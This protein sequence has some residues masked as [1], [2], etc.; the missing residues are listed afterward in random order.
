MRTDSCRAEEGP[1]LDPACLADLRARP[2]APGS[3]RDT[4][5]E[6]QAFP[7]VKIVRDADALRRVGELRHRQYV[8]NQRKAYCSIAGHDDC[9]IEQADLRAVNIYAEDE[10]GITCAMR[11]DE[12]K[13]DGD[14]RIT[15]LRR[16]SDQQGIPHRLALTCSRLVRATHHSGRHAVQLIQF[17]RLQTVSLGWR[18]CIMQTSARL[19]P[20]FQK[21]E[22]NETGIWSDDPVAGWLQVLVL[23]TR[24]RPVQ[25]R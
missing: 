7:H 4:L 16:I 12:L 23:D 13:D 9:L 18:Y 6:S 17:V 15:L 2:P 8:Q 5:Q 1:P 25:Q 22:F 24:L 14:E 3:L 20:F 19:V 11:I 10:S 21:F